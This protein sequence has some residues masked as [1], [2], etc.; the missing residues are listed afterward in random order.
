M[1]PRERVL[2]AINRQPTDRAP[3]EYSANQDVTDEL[4]EYRNATQ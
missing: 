1:T 3:A 4:M 2:Q